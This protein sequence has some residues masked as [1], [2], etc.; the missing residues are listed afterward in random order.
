[1]IQEHMLTESLRSFLFVL[2]VKAS[3][4]C[5]HKV[6]TQHARTEN[7]QQTPNT[8][9]MLVPSIPLAPQNTGGFPPQH[10]KTV[11]TSWLVVMTRGFKVLRDHSVRT[12]F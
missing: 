1:M 3:V 7:S 9:L 10:V 4:V 8:P 5:G 2:G 12:N 6:I 11:L